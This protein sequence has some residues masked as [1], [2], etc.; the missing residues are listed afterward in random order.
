MA[1][2]LS[3]ALTSTREALTSSV[4]TRLP[5]FPA[6]AA[7]RTR[8]AFM[9]GTT[10]PI[11]GHP[12][13]LSRGYWGAPVSMPSTGLDTSSAVRSRSPSRSPPDAIS[14]AVSSSLTT[15]VINQRSMRW[16]DASPRR[17]TPKGQQSFISCTAPR[18]ITPLP[19]G[20]LPRSW[21]TPVAERGRTDTDLPS[22]L[23]DATTILHDQPGRFLPE[24]R[25]VILTLPCH[26]A[27]PFPNRTL[28]GP[29]SG[30]WEARQPDR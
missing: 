15:T 4:G 14:R 28:F 10:W 8:A 26:E 6:E 7:D 16:F 2:S 11:N 17:A 27:P 19:Q 18:S 25:R 24:L 30:K 1:R 23:R 9:P 29:Q 20:N 3:P 12:P 22:D 13:G 5:T 21:R